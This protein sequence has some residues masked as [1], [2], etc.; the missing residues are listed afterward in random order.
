MKFGIDS[1]PGGTLVAVVERCP[2]FGGRVGSFDATETLKVPGVLQ[3]L[4]IK[5]DV[6]GDYNSGVAVVA[7]NTWAAIKGREV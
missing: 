2:A 3:V 7:K 1:R 6:S 5:S 4:A